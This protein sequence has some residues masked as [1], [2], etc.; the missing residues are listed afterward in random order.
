MY[1]LNSWPGLRHILYTQ[2]SPSAVPYDPGL[3]HKQ[4]R[5]AGLHK[6]THTQ[7]QRIV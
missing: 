3:S 7:S 2:F 5:Y 1:E 6:H 4:G